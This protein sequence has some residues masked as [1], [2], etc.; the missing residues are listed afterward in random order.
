MGKTVIYSSGS[1]HRSHPFKLGLAPEGR[2]IPKYQKTREEVIPLAFLLILVSSDLPQCPSLLISSLALNTSLDL[3]FAFVI[4]H[5]CS[6]LTLG[7]FHLLITYFPCHLTWL[8]LQWSWWC[9]FFFF[10]IR[11]DWQLYSTWAPNPHPWLS[12]GHFLGNV[13]AIVL[14]NRLQ[15]VQKQSSFLCHK[16]AA[17]IMCQSVPINS[18]LGHLDTEQSPLLSLSAIQP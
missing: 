13:P 11:Y 15:H 6:V 10:L 8:S 16:P 2:I 4:L 9:F 5:F 14:Q 12:S 18:P 1:D 3:W 7:L 17:W